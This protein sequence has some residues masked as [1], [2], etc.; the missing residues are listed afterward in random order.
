[1]YV[2]TYTEIK[3]HISIHVHECASIFTQVHTCKK[4]NFVAGVICNISMIAKE[5][6]DFLSNSV[7]SSLIFM[8][9]TSLTRDGGLY[10]KILALIV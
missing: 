8:D 4:Y 10:S 3:I 6:F 7:A 1:M 5:N 2:I 9:R